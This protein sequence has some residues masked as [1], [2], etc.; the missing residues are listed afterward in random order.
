MSKKAKN[1]SSFVLTWRRHFDPIEYHVLLSHLFNIGLNGNAGRLLTL[2][3]RMR[4]EGYGT[5]SVCLSVYLSVFTYSCT[6][7]TK[8][9]HERYQRL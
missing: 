9:A 5:W 3:A 2:G 4:S 7:G 8:P 1:Q 6:T